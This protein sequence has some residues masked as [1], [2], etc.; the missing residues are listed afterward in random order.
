MGDELHGSRISLEVGLRDSNYITLYKGQN[1]KVNCAFNRMREVGERN[2]VL[3]PP[4]T[5]LTSTDNNS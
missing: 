4:Q 3:K 2:G 1:P 5:H